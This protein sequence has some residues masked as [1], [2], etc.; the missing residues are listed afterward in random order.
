M[1]NGLGQTIVVDG[2]HRAYRSEKTGEPL[3]EETIGR[4][5]GD[6]STNPDYQPVSDLKIVDVN[7]PFPD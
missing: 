2:N 5:E 7:P 3:L 4:F 1:V 6:V